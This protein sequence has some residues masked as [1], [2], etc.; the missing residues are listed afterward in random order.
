M[1]TELFT[2]LETKIEQMIDEVELLRMEVSELKEAKSALEA[3]REEWSNR[4]SHLL[5]KLE[6][7]D[8]VAA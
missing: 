5:Q 2:Q 7:S 6:V 4:L 8:Q 1:Q 3:E